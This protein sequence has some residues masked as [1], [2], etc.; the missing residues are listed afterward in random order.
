MSIEE[1]LKQFNDII[2][3]SFNLRVGGARTNLIKTDDTDLNGYTYYYKGQ[4]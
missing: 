2:P 4:I 3:F 1:F